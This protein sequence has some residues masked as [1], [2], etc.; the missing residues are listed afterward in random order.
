MSG[1]DEFP[2]GNFGDSS[3]LTYWVFY[4]GATC[5]I[6]PQVSDFIQCLLEDTDKYIEVA[7][8]HHITVKQKWQVQIKM[9]DNN[10]DP[11]IATLH[12]VV[13]AP[14]Y[15]T[16]YFKSGVKSMFC[17]VAM[18]GS[19]LLSHIFIRACPFCFAVM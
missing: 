3:Q 19:P 9:C 18:K 16:G 2:S 17:N 1:N 14:D 4:S 15:A 8:V 13:L 11:F 7:D 12:N 6:T 5:H 10:G